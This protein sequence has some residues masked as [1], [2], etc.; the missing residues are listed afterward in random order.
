MG[1]HVLLQLAQL[2]YICEINHAFILHDS[3]SDLCTQGICIA[4]DAGTILAVVLLLIGI[5]IA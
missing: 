5:E 1:S 3:N 2:N 4:Q